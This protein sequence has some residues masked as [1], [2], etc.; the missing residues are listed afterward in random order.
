MLDIPAR[1]ILRPS[2][3]ASVGPA[4]WT[5]AAVEEEAARPWR[6]IGSPA[7]S[8]G[9]GASE[10]KCGDIGGGNTKRVR[11]DRLQSRKSAHEEGI[12]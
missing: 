1:A 7:G 3:P 4:A 11:I 12:Q 10:S 5:T 8:I 6:W 2:I 9:G